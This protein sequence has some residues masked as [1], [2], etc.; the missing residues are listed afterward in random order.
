MKATDEFRCNE[1]VWASM[2]VFFKQIW[3]RLIFNSEEHLSFR[4]YMESFRKSI[5][6]YEFFSSDII[7]S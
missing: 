1:I 5:D 4:K 2:S 7:L 3:Y 6:L